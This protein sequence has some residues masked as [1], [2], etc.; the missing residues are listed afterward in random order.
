MSEF[1]TVNKKNYQIEKE[2]FCER[3]GISY[4]CSYKGDSFIVKKIHHEP[5]TMYACDNTVSIELENYHRL[6]EMGVLLPAIFDYDIEKELI[7]KEYIEGESV[8]NLIRNGNEIGEILNQVRNLSF[9]VKNFGLNLDY[10]PGNFKVVNG[11]LYYMSL[12]CFPYREE[13]SFENFGNALWENR[14]ALNDY[15]RLYM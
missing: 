9:T 5:C 14:D 3:N 10:F 15:V 6:K 2:L 11:K 7:V 8:S 13:K 12:S 1:I 4:L